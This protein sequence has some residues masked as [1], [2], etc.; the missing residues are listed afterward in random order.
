MKSKLTCCF[1]DGWY[2]GLLLELGTPYAVVLLG[3]EHK[4]VRGAA[5]ELFVGDCALVEIL[6]LTNSGIVLADK[7]VNTPQSILR[8]RREG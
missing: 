2:S 4:V 8:L 7:Y 3:V 6:V 1:L 5:L